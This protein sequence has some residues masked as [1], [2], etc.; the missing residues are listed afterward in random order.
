MVY[1]LWSSPFQ[2]PS[3]SLG[4]ACR[5]KIYSIYISEGKVSSAAALFKS[6]VRSAHWSCGRQTDEKVCKTTE[7]CVLKWTATISI[8]NTYIFSRSAH[9][10]QA[11]VREPTVRVVIVW[12]GL[13]YSN[14]HGAVPHRS[15]SICICVLVSDDSS[16]HPS[17]LA[18][19]HAA[20]SSFHS[21]KLQ[22][23]ARSPAFFPTKLLGVVVTWHTK[24]LFDCDVMTCTLSRL[25]ERAKN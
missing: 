13:E 8:P 22:A 18:R 17:S 24:L 14:L 16:Q 3:F 7:Q 11:A 2:L 20:K 6:A 23:Q 1:E 10:D 4:Y 15:R 25:I 12:T 21:S 9:H 5:A 19:W